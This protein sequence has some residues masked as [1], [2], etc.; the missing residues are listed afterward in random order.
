M[1]DLQKF[2][3]KVASMR[4]SQKMY[5]AHRTQSNLQKVMLDERDVDVMLQ[6]MGFEAMKAQQLAFDALSARPMDEEQT[7]YHVDDVVHGK[8]I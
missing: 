7:R 6:E 3:R 8:K 4:K 5:F 2:V 1:S